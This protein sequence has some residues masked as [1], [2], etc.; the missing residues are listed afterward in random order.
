MPGPAEWRLIDTGPASGPRTAALDEAIARARGAGEVPDTLHFYRRDPPAVTIGYSLDAHEE[1]DIDFCRR[2]GIDI[3]R[4]LSGGGAIYTDE[5]QLVYSLATRGVLPFNVGESLKAVCTAVARGISSLGVEAVFAPVNDVLVGGR[6][7]SGSAQMRKWGIV[8]QHGTVLVDSDP[9]VM[10]CALRVPEAKR[11]RHA[12]A[13]PSLRVTTLREQMGRL[14]SMEEVKAALAASFGETFNASI[15]L[16]RLTD[17]EERMAVQ[18]VRE[19]Y[20]NDGWNLRR[21]E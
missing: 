3:V 20:G 8:L 12:A 10:F 17:K 4:R 18:L 19:R 1:V 16:G 11:L 5:R 7:V 21:R 9:K 15:V 14:P 13:D 2:R 6:K